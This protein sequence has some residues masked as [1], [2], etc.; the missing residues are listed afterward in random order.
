M[1]ICPIG[2]CVLC[3]QGIDTKR[4]HHNDQDPWR[5]VRDVVDDFCKKRH[6]QI[7]VWLRINRGWW[8][9]ILFCNRFYDVIDV[10]W[11]IIVP[12]STL[13]VTHDVCWCVDDDWGRLWCFEIKCR[14]Y[15]RQKFIIKQETE[16]SHDQVG[17]KF[18]TDVISQVGPISVFRLVSPETLCKRLW[19]IILQTLSNFDKWWKQ[20]LQSRYRKNK[21]SLV[22]KWGHDECTGELG[23]LARPLERVLEGVSRGHSV[24]GSYRI[25]HQP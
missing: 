19:E 21:T 25:S 16:K 18:H 10:G 17:P 20:V 15:A 3:E 13:K 5:P 2:F 8:G 23:F 7:C 14:K 4:G 11:F 24:N 22:L 12:F 1:S 6:R 9:R